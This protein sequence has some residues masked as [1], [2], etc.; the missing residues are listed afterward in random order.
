V[1]TKIRHYHSAIFSSMEIGRKQGNSTCKD[2]TYRV[3]RAYDT[4]SLYGIPSVN[5]QNLVEIS[6]V[7]GRNWNEMTN[8]MNFPMTTSI[9]CCGAGPEYKLLHSNSTVLT[10]FSGWTTCGSKIQIIALMATMTVRVVSELFHSC[11][12][13]VMEGRQEPGDQV[14]A[15]GGAHFQALELCRVDNM[16]SNIVSRITSGGTCRSL[17]Y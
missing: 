3:Y 14:W 17:N 16:N 13:E 6:Y 10:L 4:A 5:F 11:R 9:W 12:G 7:K 1:E 8:V 2:C 15:Q